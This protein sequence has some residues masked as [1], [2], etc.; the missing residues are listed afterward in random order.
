MYCLYEENGPLNKKYD[1]S[2]LIKDTADSDKTNGRRGIFLLKNELFSYSFRQVLEISNKNGKQI[3]YRCSVQMRKLF[4]QFI[5]LFVYD[6]LA[7]F[8]SFS[9]C[10]KSL[11]FSLSSYSNDQLIRKCLFHSLIQLI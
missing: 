9:C 7:N 8:F 1:S 4:L 5:H 10:S 3:N 2:K 11:F 6:M